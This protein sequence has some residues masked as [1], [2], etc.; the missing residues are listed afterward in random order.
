[1][2]AKTSFTK[3]RKRMRADSVEDV[4]PLSTSANYQRLSIDAGTKHLPVC[5]LN[6]AINA[7]PRIV[8]R[9]SGMKEPLTVAICLPPQHEF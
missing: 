7:K 5:Q 8:P 4:V 1:V 9:A 2:T 3:V 6:R